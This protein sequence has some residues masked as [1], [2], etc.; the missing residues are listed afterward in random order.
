MPDLVYLSGCF[1]T[2]IVLPEEKLWQTNKMKNQDLWMCVVWIFEGS[3][4]RIFVLGG[5]GS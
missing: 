3:K 1:V 2:G 5:A 4:A